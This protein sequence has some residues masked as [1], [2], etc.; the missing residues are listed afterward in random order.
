MRI[1]S[2]R[3]L[4]AVRGGGLCRDSIIGSPA[5]T[6]CC[7]CVAYGHGSMRIRASGTTRVTNN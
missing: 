6:R 7:A 3:F 4:G 5:R 2:A 1:S